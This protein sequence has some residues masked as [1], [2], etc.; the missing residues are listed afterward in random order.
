MTK[1]VGQGLGSLLAPCRAV[2]RKQRSNRES[3]WREGPMST[4]KEKRTVNRGAVVVTQLKARLLPIPEDP[5]SN[6]LIGNFY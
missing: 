6:P 3:D 4:A 1:E 2:C 5:G